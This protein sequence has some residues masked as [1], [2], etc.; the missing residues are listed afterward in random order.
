MSNQ[1]PLPFGSFDRF[2]FEIFNAGPNRQAVDY[3]QQVISSTNGGYVYLWGEQGTGKSH[4][5]Q[6]A[7][8]QAATGGHKVIYIPLQQRQQIAPE[9]LQ[10]MESLDLVCID[11]VDQIA[12][13]AA[14]EIAVFNLYNQLSA[15]HNQLV[16]S[17]QSSPQGLAIRLPDLKSRLAAGVTWHLSELNEQERLQALQQRAKMRGFE[18]P[19]EVIEYLSRRVARDMHSLFDW[20]DRLDQ[21]T[22]ASKKKLTVPFVRELLTRSV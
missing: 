22:L 7:C 3:L 11:D 13:D 15:N 6:A 12:G 21:A 10:G 1:I 19:D 14:W 5:L 9:L 20:L 2:N 4:L 8:T 17:A 18:L 16:I